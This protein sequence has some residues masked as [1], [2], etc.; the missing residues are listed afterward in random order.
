[1]YTYLFTIVFNYLTMPYIKIY[2]QYILPG[3]LVNL[4]EQNFAHQ[5]MTSSTFHYNLFLWVGIRL[6]KSIYYVY[7]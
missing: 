4:G 1:M 2:T 5:A 3:N 6:H 7:T